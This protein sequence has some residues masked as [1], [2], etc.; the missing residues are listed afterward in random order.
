MEK[1]SVQKS[2]LLPMLGVFLVI[3]LMVE[4][5]GGW[6][7]EMGVKTWYPTIQKP[8]WVP[9][10]W[11]FGPVWTV[12]YIMMAFSLW[13]VWKEPTTAPKAMAYRLFAAQLCVNLIWSALFFTFECP[14]CAL[15]DIVVLWLLVAWTIA[16]F[17]A[18]RPLAGFLLIPYLL[19]VSYA[20]A[21]NASIW[22]LNRVH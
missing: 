15:I 7:T 4:L 12:L 6:F 16:S 19:W 2:N 10:N 9:P 22:Y 14:L 21:L 18:I 8:T 3:C 1:N 5:L 20:M 17:Y 11:V 13:L